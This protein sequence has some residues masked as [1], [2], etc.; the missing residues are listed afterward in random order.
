MEYLQILF[1]G[2]TY[3]IFETGDICRMCWIL[4]TY[5]HLCTGEN[6]RL[7]DT[8][9]IYR[10]ICTL[11]I[12]ELFVTWDISDILAHML[13]IFCLEQWVRTDCGHIR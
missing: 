13:I 4:D 7:F 6:D 5:K 12:Y 11:E 1:S 2:E 3:I 10:K 9:D 8:G